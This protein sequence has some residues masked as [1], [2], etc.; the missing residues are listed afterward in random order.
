MDKLFKTLNEIK[1]LVKQ[2]TPSVKPSTAP[3][4]PSIKTI[5]P[6]SLTVKKP[7]APEIPGVPP[8]S[9][10]DPKKMAEQLKNPT[11]RK[12]KIEMLKFDNNGQW[13]LD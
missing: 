3:T 2:F 9:G 7:K 11:E 8:I 5:Q 1:E 4:L 13:S 6:P 12:A 10:K